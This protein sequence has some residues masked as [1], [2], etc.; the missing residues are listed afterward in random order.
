MLIFNALFWIVRAS[1]GNS[2]F[3]KR[4]AVRRSSIPCSPTFFSYGSVQKSCVY[5]CLGSSSVIS[6]NLTQKDE[7]QENLSS[8]P[9]SWPP[10]RSILLRQK[11]NFLGK[12]QHSLQKVHLSFLSRICP[13]SLNNKKQNKT[14]R[15]DRLLMV[16]MQDRRLV[17]LERDGSTIIEVANLES[18]SAVQCNDMVVDDKVRGGNNKNHTF[19][20][21]FFDH[22]KKLTKQGF[23]CR[24]VLS[25][26]PIS[27]SSSWKSWI[28]QKWNFSLWKKS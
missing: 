17:R 1:Y 22:K 26:F 18:A 25:I 19:F 4:T 24:T 6:K 15:E 12:T 5:N 20:F 14:G 23:S 9:T 3:W 27:D 2:N 10:Y 13:F 28:F 16:S 11:R 8:I 7:F 21:V